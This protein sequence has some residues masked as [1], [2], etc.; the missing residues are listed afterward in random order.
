MLTAWDVAP[1]LL[2]NAITDSLSISTNLYRH[3]SALDI[4]FQPFL[5]CRFDIFV[6]FSVATKV[7]SRFQAKSSSDAR[8]QIRTIPELFAPKNL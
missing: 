2:T 8:D 3:P 1:S 6:I 7:S 5:F 4:S